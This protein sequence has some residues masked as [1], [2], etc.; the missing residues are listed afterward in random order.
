[1]AKLNV[2]SPTVYMFKDDRKR[3]NETVGQAHPAG[4]TAVGDLFGL[5]T[6]VENE[7]I[8]HL[9][10]GKV[11]REKPQSEKP[12]ERVKQMRIELR[13]KFCLRRVGKWLYN[14]KRDCEIFRNEIAKDLRVEPGLF[15]TLKPPPK[16][17]LL[18]MA[19]FS[20]E[21]KMEL[22]PYL[23]SMDAV[24]PKG[25]ISL[26]DETNVFRRVDEIGK[27]TECDSLVNLIG[28][29]KTDSEAT[30]INKDR[31]PPDVSTI[32]KEANT[33]KDSFHTVVRQKEMDS[34]PQKEDV[35][36]PRVE[37]G[38]VRYQASDL[39]VYMF[40][41][42]KQM[43][44]ELVLQYPDVET[45]GDL[46]GLWTTEGDAVLHVVL[47][48]GKYCRRTNVSFHQD[49]PY[50]QRN[51]ELLTEKYMLCHIGEWHSHHQ[52]CL[53]EPSN[54]DS[55]TVIRNYPSGAKYGFLLII[56]NITARGK[57]KLSPYLYTERSTYTYD[58][59]GE[60]ISLR[61]HNIF[62][63]TTEIKNS[64]E[65]GKE[66]ELD[67]QLGQAR[68]SQKPY[69]TTVDTGYRQ[70][71]RRTYPDPHVT[72][73][74]PMEVDVYP[75]R[76]SPTGKRRSNRQKDANVNP[77]RKYSKTKRHNFQERRN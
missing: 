35:M 21:H 53:F 42:D 33:N 60:V 47:G 8:V 50:L 57:V 63:N 40:E 19:N 59:A 75:E 5:W 72:T 74:E 66:T 46:F 52:L 73:E 7:S 43:M 14:G 67:V 49:I 28:Q 26:L 12:S 30:K 1:M 10:T 70:P 2:P 17:V 4:Q 39:K 24:S 38:F 71:P 31:L 41:E 69:T 3:I 36:L 16:Y 44:E 61:S 64:I 6:D 11:S 54:G 76:S 51:G 22:S 23:V 56:A 25:T 34:V 27:I 9:V 58:N 65:R 13:D 15:K 29:E 20:N 37:L 48:P 77:S 18:I 55:S 68:R 62:K 45:G 32:R